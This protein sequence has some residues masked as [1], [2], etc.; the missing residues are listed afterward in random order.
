MTQS[1]ENNSFTASDIERYHNGTMSAEER[2]ALEKAALDDPFLADALEGYHYTTTAT[3]D[4]VNLQNRLDEKTR[5]R[6]ILPFFF[7]NKTWLRAAAIILIVAG[8]T[9][10]LFKSSSQENKSVA[11]EKQVEAKNDS[12]ITNP[13]ETSNYVMP[14]QPLNISTDSVKEATSQSG[15]K[16]QKQE[17][18]FNFSTVTSSS[19][20]K[21]GS[22]ETVLM[23]N[24]SARKIPGRADES[25]SHSVNLESNQN[26]FKTNSGILSDSN[27][28]L[29]NATANN[30]VLNRKAVAN[31]N[32][33]KVFG[34]SNSQ[35]EQVKMDAG[36]YRIGDTIRNVNVVMTPQPSAALEEVVVVGYGSQKKKPAVPEG[37]VKGMVIDTLEPAE[38]WTNFDDYVAS[39]LKPPEDF[40]DKPMSGE[41]Q[42]S[43]DV[44]E[45]G[46]PINIAV[47]KS[48][49]TKCD[50][51]A[52]R[53]LKEGPKW[54]KKKAKK[55]KV[56]IRF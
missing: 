5:R 54:K 17:G 26:S 6:K 30:N 18:R 32:F 9:W 4:I 55:G 47:I 37:R 41:V 50:E 2:H 39:H 36:A 25:N 13:G 28:V 33:S 46:E 23:D 43:F 51:E 49:C 1:P 44:N 15:L 14:G 21:Q 20:E 29:S 45:A 56:T 19:T 16:K 27:R 24:K 12:A 42:L 11:I 34:E 10:L 3:E 31:D 22:T 52:I 8:G 48:L 40:K 7:E 53:L 38:G 35:R